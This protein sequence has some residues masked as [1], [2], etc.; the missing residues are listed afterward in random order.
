MTAQEYAAKNNISEKEAKKALN[1]AVKSGKMRKTVCDE[2]IY[3]RIRGY[4]GKPMPCKITYYY[5]ND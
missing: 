4:S 5:E 1:A 3:R 2:M